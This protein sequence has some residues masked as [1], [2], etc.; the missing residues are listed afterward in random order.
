M[1][2]QY[3]IPLALLSL[4]GTP[5]LGRNKDTKGR[6]LQGGT[7][8]SIVHTQPALPLLQWWSHIYATLQLGIW[9]FKIL[10][11]LLSKEGE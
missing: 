11:S 6:S 1:K 4:L 5:L 7:A 8:G 10:F 3:P 2:G 9:I